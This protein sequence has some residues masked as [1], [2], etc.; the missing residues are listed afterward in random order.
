MELTASSPSSSVG[1]A[2]WDSQPRKL[3]S[4]REGPA[5]PEGWQLGAGVDLP[6]P[7][8]F[9]PPSAETS[10]CSTQFSG[11][12][13]PAPSAPGVGTW[14]GQDGP[15]QILRPA[16]Q[17]PAVPVGWTPVPPEVTC[18]LRRLPPHTSPLVHPRSPPRTTA[19][20]PHLRSAPGTDLQWCLPPLTHLITPNNLQSRY[21]YPCF[22]SKGL[23]RSHPCPVAQ[24]LTD[25]AHQGP[26]QRLTA[27]LGPEGTGRDGRRLAHCA[28]S[29]NW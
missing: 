9:S 4:C 13:P 17:S 2:R 5:S 25:P 21:Y 7:S 28:T 26:Q 16:L 20:D 14:W 18:S 15:C 22:I 29:S 27:H 10:K 24:L 11:H 8:Y 12:I 23:E 1:A 6:R 19:C 3:A